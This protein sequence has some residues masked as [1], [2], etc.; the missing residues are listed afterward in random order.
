VRLVSLG[1]ALVLAVTLSACGTAIPPSGAP[2]APINQSPTLASPSPVAATPGATPAG[3]L[4]SPIPV[5]TGLLDLI[6]ATLDGLSRQTDVAVDARIA[7]DPDLAALATSFATALYIDPASGNF[8]YVS[9][10]RLAHPLADEA[11]RDYRDSFDEA[12]CSQAGGKTGTASATLGGRS[13][14]IGSCAGGVHTYHALLPE[15]SVIASVS[16]LGDRRLGEK[17]MTQLANPGAS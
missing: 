4:A 13:V 1:S 16:S 17:L 2:P 5:D 15:E 7:R 3:S 14:D 8:A 10:V 6:P 12:A 11:Y 9:L